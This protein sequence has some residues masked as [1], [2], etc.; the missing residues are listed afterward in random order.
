M[1]TKVNAIA[2]LAAAGCAA[3]IAGCGNNTPAVKTYSPAEQTQMRQQAIVQIQNN[4][5]IPPD[6]KASLIALIEHP[7]T[8]D[9][10]GPPRPQ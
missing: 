1:R 5:Q 3:F 10:P 4:S 2:A 8:N 6:K 7:Q 9:V